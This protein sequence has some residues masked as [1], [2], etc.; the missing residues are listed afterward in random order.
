MPLLSRFAEPQGAS[1]YD[2]TVMLE[3]KRAERDLL[4]DKLNEMDAVIEEWQDELAH[5]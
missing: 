4:Q 2:L 3:E 1:K 5:M